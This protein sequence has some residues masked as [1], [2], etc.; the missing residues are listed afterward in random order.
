MTGARGSGTSII[1]VYPAATQYA[2]GRLGVLSIASYKS[3]PDA[4]RDILNAVAKGFAIDWSGHFDEI[5]GEDAS[6]SDCTDALLAAVT[7]AVYGDNV[8]A[9]TKSYRFGIRSPCTQAEKD[10]AVKEGW[11]FFPTA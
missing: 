1:E 11:I 9:M 5:V 8:L 2:F 7:G 6:A 3:D 4:R 10:D